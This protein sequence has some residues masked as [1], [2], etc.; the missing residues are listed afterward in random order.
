MNFVTPDVGNSPL[1]RTGTYTLEV[2]REIAPNLVMF[3]EGFS[4]EERV[5]TVSTALEYEWTEHV[6]T[7]AVYSYTEE[8][9]SIFRLGFNVE[10]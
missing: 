5:K 6:N 7:F 8:H 9:E 10:Y 2:E 1:Q 4:T 3:L